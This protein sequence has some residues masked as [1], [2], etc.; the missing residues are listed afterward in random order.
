MFIHKPGQLGI[1]MLLLIGMLLYVILFK[2]KLVHAL[3]RRQSH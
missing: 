2:K 1:N 3:K